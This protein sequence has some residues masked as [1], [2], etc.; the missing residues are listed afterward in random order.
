MECYSES[1]GVGFKFDSLYKAVQAINA[2]CPHSDLFF[3]HASNNITRLSLDACK[4]I[5]QPSWRIYPAYDIWVRLT[6]W[7]FPLLQ[8]IAQFSRPPLGLRGEAFAVIHLIGNP[9]NTIFSLLRKLVTCQQRASWFRGELVTCQRGARCGTLATCQRRASCGKLEDNGWKE[10]ALIV[11]SCDESGQGDNARRAIE[12]RL[13]PQLLRPKTDWNAE[14]L[15]AWKLYRRAARMLA[16]DRV[17]KFFPVAIALCLFISSITIAI[18]RLSSSPSNPINPITVEA[19]S[20]AFSALYFYIITAVFLSSM[21]GASQSEKSIPRILKTLRNPG[22]P[23]YMDNQTRL[24]E[25]GLYSWQP[26]QGGCIDWCLYALATSMVIIGPLSSILISWYTPPEGWGCRHCAYATVLSLYAISSLLDIPIGRRFWYAFTKDLIFGLA[27]LT[28]LGMAQLGIYNS[29][30]CWSKFGKAGIPLPQ[31]DIVYQVL[32]LRFRTIF[33]PIT[34]ACI[35]I[36]IIF[37][38]I[39]CWWFHDAYTVLLQRDD[40][41]L[42]LPWRS[43]LYWLIRVVC[44]LPKTVYRILWV[45][46]GPGTPRPSY[47]GVGGTDIPM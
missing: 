47:R 21:I 7:K 8:L 42:N 45:R 44:W 28:L 25:G 17:T 35:G 41:L 39:S 1:R 16:A 37:C 9:V 5:G 3:D 29:C 30:I 13:V 11:I 23:Y 22:M 46:A 32:K 24:A 27:N 15:R 12:N 34:L 2:T 14:E 36:H 38:I 26:W 18:A 19:H 4:K 43:V 10:L 31:E 33:T 40:G 20:I 6:V